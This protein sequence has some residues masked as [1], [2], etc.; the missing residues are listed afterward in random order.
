MSFEESDT[1]IDNPVLGA[2]ER[3]PAATFGPAVAGTAPSEE[4][5]DASA[6]RSDP[7][8][9]HIRLAA[10]QSRARSAWAPGAAAIGVGAL[11]GVGVVVAYARQSPAPSSDGPA[12][13]EAVPG[14]VIEVGPSGPDRGVLVLDAIEPGA[15]SVRIASPTWATLWAGTEPTLELRGL[16]AGDYSTRVTPSGGSAIRDTVEVRAGQTCR[17]T[18]ASG[19][20][21]KWTDEGCR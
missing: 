8:M 9:P 20:A 17:Y 7:T 10:P 5:T 12:L 6:P 3:R 4:R 18:F 14:G 21:T 15:A 16:P 13:E 19:Q 1:A 2:G 11:L